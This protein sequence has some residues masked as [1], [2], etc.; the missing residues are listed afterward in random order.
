MDLQGEASLVDYQAKLKSMDVRSVNFL[1]VNP[2]KKV[3]YLNFQAETSFKEDKAA[4]NM[5]ATM[6]QLFEL[7]RLQNNHELERLATVSRNSQLYLGK[8]R[9]AAGARGEAPQVD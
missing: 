6:P 7:N 1:L 9:M 4:R 8:E 2:G 5:R 3:S